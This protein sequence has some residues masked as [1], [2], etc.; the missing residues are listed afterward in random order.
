MGFAP[1]TEMRQKLSDFGP[2]PLA[3]WKPCKFVARCHWPFM[4]KCEVNLHPLNPKN[5]GL[6]QM[7]FPFKRWFVRFDVSFLWSTPKQLTLEATLPK[8]KIAPENRPCFKPKQSPN[9]CSL[10][11]IYIYIIILIF[12]FREGTYHPLKKG[13]CSRSKFFLM[14]LPCSFCCKSD[15]FGFLNHPVFEGGSCIMD[16]GWSWCFNK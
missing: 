11:T 13:Q 14:L 6:V 15:I 5:G 2:N 1:P 12:L 4:T 7:I 9:H 16:H 10:S 8:P 3:C